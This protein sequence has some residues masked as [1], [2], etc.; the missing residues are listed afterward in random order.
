MAWAS[1]IMLCKQSSAEQRRAAMIT[2]AIMDDFW[3]KFLKA[4]DMAGLSG[5]LSGDLLLQ[6]RP[7][8]TF[9]RMYIS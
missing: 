7:E 5:R 9:F 3:T 6:A 4:A 1:L 2:I 8:T